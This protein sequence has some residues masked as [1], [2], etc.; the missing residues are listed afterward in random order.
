MKIHIFCFLILSMVLAQAQ[1]TTSISRST[2]APFNVVNGSFGIGSSTVETILSGGTF[3]TDPGSIINI[4]APIN[5]TIKNGG[6]LG[7][8]FRGNGGFGSGVERLDHWYSVDGIHM[9]RVPGYENYVPPNVSGHAA[10]CRDSCEILLPGHKYLVAYTVASNSAFGPNCGV[11]LSTDAVHLTHLSEI[12]PPSGSTLIVVPRLLID[13]PSGNLYVTVNDNADHFKLIQS[14]SNDGVSWGTG[15]ASFTSSTGSTM[16][17]RD[18]HLS[19]AS[20]F[21][22]FSWFKDSDGLNHMSTNTALVSTG[23]VDQGALT[24][25]ISGGEGASKVQLADGTWM[26]FMSGSGGDPNWYMMTAP[27]LSSNS[28]SAPVATVQPAYDHLANPTQANAGTYDNG[29]ELLVTDAQTVQDILCATAPWERSQLHWDSITLNTG[30]N[31]GTFSPLYLGYTS[32]GSYNLLSFNGL[33]TPFSFLGIMGRAPSGDNGVTVQTQSNGVFDIRESNGTNTI[34]DCAQFGPTSARLSPY[35]TNGFVK[36]SSANGTLAI[37]TNTYITGNQTIT[38]S[39]DTTGTGTT[40]ITTTTSKINGVALGSLATG[41]LMNTTTTGAPSIVTIGT[42]LSFSGSTLSNTVTG[43]VTSFSSGNLSPL[44]TTSVSTA[45]TTPALT[46]A[47]TNASALSWFGN[48]TGGSAA[49]SYN[50]TPLPATMGGTGLTTIADFALLDANNAFTG[51]NTFTNDHQTFNTGSDA[52]VVI[53]RQTTGSYNAIGLRGGVSNTTLVGIMAGAGGDDSLTIAA[54]GNGFAFRKSGA[55]PSNIA[56]ISS[57]GNIIPTGIIYGSGGTPSH[58]DGTNSTATVTGTNIDGTLQVVV[59]G[60]VSSGIIT[61][62]TL[63]NS[64]TF[65]TKAIMTLTAANAATATLAVTTFPFITG[66]ATTIV[67]NTGAVGLPIGT[68]LW[69][70]HTGGY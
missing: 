43:T 30:V 17:G 51:S 47:L 61:T 19:Y 45:T 69:N 6:L 66:T 46:Y 53:G 10:G 40:A 37:D 32:D 1:G 26:A 41:V 20:G 31:A 35:T 36:T 28:F 11:A 49:P 23:W 59:A 60:G 7:I 62:V 2:V 64:L 33:N 21:Y 50:T 42:G 68:Y 54:G 27:N 3:T 16:T 15:S 55:S 39:G 13:P 34:R 38:L 8:N 67:M 65:P 58:A 44:F 56:A 25:W 22:Y 63:A 48:A 12:P 14:T 24:N 52:T 18:G 29:C 70:Y 57:S 5:L 4:N 9:V